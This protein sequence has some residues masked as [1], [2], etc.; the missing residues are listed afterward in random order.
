MIKKGAGP[1]TVK[2]LDG[3]IKN[4]KECGQE[5]KERSNK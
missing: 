5:I 2:I 3:I 1:E 4:G